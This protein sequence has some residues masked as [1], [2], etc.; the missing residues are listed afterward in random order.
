MH[1][2]VARSDPAVS[3]ASSGILTTTLTFSSSEQL[4][5]LAP[6]PLPP[7]LGASVIRWLSIVRS[8]RFIMVIRISIITHVA[9][10]VILARPAQAQ[11]P[12]AVPPAAAGSA[13]LASIPN[14]I[15]NLDWK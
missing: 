15:K 10:L 13:N 6:R 2:C 1:G 11:Q 14:A 9:W 4:A 7:R 3:A 8:W 5:L 12:A